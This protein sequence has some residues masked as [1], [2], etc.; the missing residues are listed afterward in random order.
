V[1]PSGEDEDGSAGGVGQGGVDACDCVLYGAAHAFVVRF[2]DGDVGAIFEARYFR[3]RRR[4]CLR[5]RV[6]GR[7]AGIGIC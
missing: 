2:R 6:S 4:Q 1:L 7:C 5:D 3:W